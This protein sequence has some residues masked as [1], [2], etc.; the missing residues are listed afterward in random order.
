VA[1]PRPDVRRPDKLAG[2]GHAG[3][4]RHNVEVI[5]EP[6]NQAG[7]QVSRPRRG[8]G[9]VN[10]R[11]AHEIRVADGHDVGRRRPVDPHWRERTVASD[12][13]A[14]RVDEHAGEIA[15]VIG[16]HVGEEYRSQARKVESRVRIRRRR[17]ATA[18]DQQHVPVDDERRAD[19]GPARH[20]H[21]CSGRPQQDQFCGH[22]PSR[23][24]ASARQKPSQCREGLPGNRDGQPG[25][26][27]AGPAQA[28]HP[29][30]AHGAV[31]SG[32]QR[33]IRAGV[34]LPHDARVAGDSEGNGARDRHPVHESG[35]VVVVGDRVVLG[36]AVSQMAV[37][38]D[39]QF[40]RTVFSSRVRC[41][42][43]KAKRSAESELDSPARERTT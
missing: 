25:R 22:A 33:G 11:L 32:D 8:I 15:D 20:G 37:S 2:I 26:I 9:P 23:A 31:G 43:S 28:T 1:C 21:R 42:C 41:R 10:G 27:G 14:P 39:R 35:L 13:A 38:P 4:E 17:P 30:P 34:A 36:G 7:D 12:A 3:I 40:Q 18:V 5:S 16:V 29:D 19:P 24:R 6:G